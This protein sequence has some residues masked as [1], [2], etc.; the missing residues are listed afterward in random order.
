QENPVATINGAK[1]YEV[2]KHLALTGHQ[3]NPQSVII[4]KKFWEK[5]SVEEKK[6]VGD[7]AIESA[8]FQREKAR[9][10]ESSIL[11]NLKKNGMQVTLLPEAEM[12]K[13][14][15]KMR[16]VTAKYG[17]TVGQDL[18]KELQTEIEKFRTAAAAPA[19]K[20]GK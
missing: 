17:V 1:L 13:L 18:V 9:A 12:S 19:K 3:Y 7:A 20:S 5:L 15:D 8:K 14:R 6:I 4:S 2:Q 16:P 10:L 11:D